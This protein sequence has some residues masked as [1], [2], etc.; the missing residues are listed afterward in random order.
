MS[1]LSP[2]SQAAPF[3]GIP[4][5]LSLAAL[6]AG[7]SA[8]VVFTTSSGVLGWAFLGVF[9]ATVVLVSLL[10]EPRALFLMVASIPLLFSIAIVVCGWF[11]VEMG[12]GNHEGGLSATQKITTIY[13]LLQHFPV[14]AVGTL[15][16]AVISG[17]RLALHK[18]NAKAAH[19][20]ELQSRREAST[21]NEQTVEQA[22][23]A[24]SRV[25]HAAADDAQSV[26]VEE[27]LQRNRKGSRR[28]R[29]LQSSVSTPS[30][31]APN[32]EV[33]A[34]PRPVR[35][36]PQAQQATEGPR[37][38]QQAQRSPRP[39]PQQSQQ[40]QQPQ[41]TPRPAA[42]QGQQAQRSQRP[43]A[44]QAQRRSATSAQP[45]TE[46]FAARPQR[47]GQPA[48]PVRQPRSQSAAAGSALPPKPV[49]KKRVPQQSAQPKPG[50]KKAVR[51]NPGTPAQGQVRAGQKPPVKRV[52]K[53][54]TQAPKRRSRFDDD[55]YSD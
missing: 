12:S 35:K 34:P 20:R 39:H 50:V 53:K 14:L 25:R 24:R 51:K 15:A 26:T 55:L 36:K 33:V 43:N 49:V 2:K 31:A 21:R 17:L 40:G 4:L 22:T 47:E 23:R 30:P 52:V 7:L 48:R 11:L 32:A 19:E 38:R 5:W 13:P 54:T 42:Q 16:A 3:Y 18:H 6:V 44:Q 27:L 9:L 29:K 1:T 8:G 46:T 37:V 28:S 45:R 41:R 10:T